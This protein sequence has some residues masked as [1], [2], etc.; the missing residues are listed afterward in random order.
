HRHLVGSMRGDRVL[1]GK[2]PRDR[3]RREFLVRQR[4]PRPPA[5]R[6][7]RAGGVGADEFEQFQWH[8]SFC[9]KSK[10]VIARSAATKQ[11]SL[12]CLLW[13]ASPS[14]SSGTHSRDPLARNDGR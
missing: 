4:H 14:L 10:P 8:F 5:E 7:E 11:S 3:F 13:I 1:F 6:T 2:A 12:A 9:K